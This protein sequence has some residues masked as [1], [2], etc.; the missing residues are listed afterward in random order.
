VKIFPYLA[1]VLIFWFGCTDNPN[2][3]EPGPKGF[4]G[5]IT[6][7]SGHPIVGVDIHYIYYFSPPRA[8]EINAAQFM[9]SV[10][11]PDTVSIHIL[12]PYLKIISTIA[13]SLY[14]SEGNYSVLFDSS[15]TNGIYRA[16]IIVGDSTIT[17]VFPIRVTNVD[18]LLN[19]GALNLADGN[20]HFYFDYHTLGLG[21]HFTQVDPG[22]EP[23]DD[24]SVRD[25]ITLVLSH[26]NYQ[27]LIQGVRLDTN[28]YS[29]G[30]FILIP[31]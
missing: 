26:P 28:S 5:R 30:H 18:T 19:T 1:I 29:N 12:N 15:V 9:F 17:Q 21:F 13:D 14:L 27:T 20:G 3:V 4:Y 23:I 25:S 24:F 8:G 16:Q 10:S 11:S 2:T 22:G 7:E 6:D 31:E